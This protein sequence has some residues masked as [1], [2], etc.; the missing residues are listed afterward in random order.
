M[1]ESRVMLL[2]KSLLKKRLE[3]FE[4]LQL[5]ESG[6]QALKEHEIEME[7][8]AQKANMMRLFDQLIER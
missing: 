5:T 2:R 6:W 1:S 4:R 8:E 3:I 7:E